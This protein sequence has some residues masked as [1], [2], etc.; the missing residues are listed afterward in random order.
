MPGIYLSIHSLVLTLNCSGG[1]AKEVGSMGKSISTWC[2]ER[3]IY[4]LINMFKIK[5]ICWYLKL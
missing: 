1:R 4:N 3:R 2:S 5:D